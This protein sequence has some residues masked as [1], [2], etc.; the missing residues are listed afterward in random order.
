M[1]LATAALSPAHASPTCLDLLLTSLTTPTDVSVCNLLALT[2]G[3]IVGV[4]TEHGLFLQTKDGATSTH[5]GIDARRKQIEAVHF[6][7]RHTYPPMD[8]AEPD[9]KQCYYPCYG[10]HRGPGMA[11][12]PRSMTF[13]C[14]TAAA[15]LVENKSTCPGWR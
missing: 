4:R 8:R 13:V 10:T 3:Q 12:A 9:A 6:A 2:D 5:Y 7:R 1:A 15:F 14:F 11:T